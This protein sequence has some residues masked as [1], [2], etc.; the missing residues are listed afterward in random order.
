MLPLLLLQQIVGS[1]QSPRGDVTAIVDNMSRQLESLEE[2]LE[3]EQTRADTHLNALRVLSSLG[4]RAKTSNDRAE[5]LW[6]QGLKDV[7][8]LLLQLSERNLV[9][10]DEIGY[11]GNRFND[12]VD[13]LNR[14]R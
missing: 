10:I 11:I 7:S 9:E 3:E 8:E 4:S 5:S 6:V 2:S 14:D 12:S 13:T 1:V